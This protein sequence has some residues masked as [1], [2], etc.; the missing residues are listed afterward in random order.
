MH[1]SKH[2]AYLK[3]SKPMWLEQRAREIDEIKDGKYKT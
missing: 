2:V 3:E 1:Y